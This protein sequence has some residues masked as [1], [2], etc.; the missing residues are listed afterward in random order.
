MKGVLNIIDDLNLKLKDLKK[1]D[2]VI[3]F[4]KLFF[5]FY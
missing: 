5:L 3:S 1:K 2:Y 4:F